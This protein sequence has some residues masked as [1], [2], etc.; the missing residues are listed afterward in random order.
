MRDLDQTEIDGLEAMID[1]AGLAAVLAA[2]ATICHDKA[3]HVQ[4]NWQDT[5]RARHWTRAA[6]VIERAACHDQVNT[7]P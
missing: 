5:A 3:E 1:A 7:L 2:L 6:K 4:S